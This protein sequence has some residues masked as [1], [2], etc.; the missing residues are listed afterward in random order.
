MASI[1]EMC[2]PF[3]TA[4]IGVTKVCGGRPDVARAF[5]AAGAVGLADARL[6]NLKRLRQAGLEAPLILLRSPALSVVSEVVETVQ[7][8][9]N[10]EPVVLKALSEAAGARGLEHQVLL[11]VDL[12]ELR[13]G[14]WEDEL[15]NL[16]T[17]ARSLP[18]LTV[19]GIG[20]NRVPQWGRSYS[21]YFQRLWTLPK[22]AAI[23]I[24]A[25]LGQLQRLHVRAVSG[26]E[27]DKPDQQL[28]HR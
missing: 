20:A 28:A 5:L 22:H 23:L 19:W 14:V 25:S 21:E 16:Y 17:Y 4:V 24:C 8:S 3:G 2:R 27:R 6:A 1:V 10:S 26:L 9:A 7:I 15:L 13:E 11:M 18:N 12:G